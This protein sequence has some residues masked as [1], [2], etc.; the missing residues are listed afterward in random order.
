MNVHRINPL[1]PLTKVSSVEKTKRPESV[2]R[3]ESIKVSGQA[4]EAAVLK[5]AVDI[6][7]AAPE[8]RMD[9]VEIAKRNI[10][11]P[12]YIQQALEGTAEN[13]MKAFGL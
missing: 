3:P 11:N 10:D 7:K 6:A 13:I 4:R 8:I 5:M 1:D 9:K 12:A 2:E